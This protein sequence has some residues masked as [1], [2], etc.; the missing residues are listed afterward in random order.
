[1]DLGSVRGE[2]EWL[3]KIGDFKKLYNIPD[4]VLSVKFLD[5]YKRNPEL[6]E[7]SPTTLTAPPLGPS[8]PPYQH[9]CDR[10]KGAVKRGQ[11]KNRPKPRN[12]DL[13][14]TQAKPKKGHKNTV[15]K[16]DTKHDTNKKDL[17]RQLEILVQDHIENQL[18]Q[19]HS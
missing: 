13:E 2:V 8:Q 15:P 1:M 19:R 17:Y 3:N 5:D 12:T 16:K 6:N 14:H 18:K 11:K 7:A 4:H 10:Q 9:K